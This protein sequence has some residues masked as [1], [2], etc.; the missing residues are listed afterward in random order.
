[1]KLLKDMQI[2][3]NH[4]FNCFEWSDLNFGFLLIKIFICFLIVAFLFFVLSFPYF[5]GGWKSKS[6]YF[7][8]LDFSYFSILYSFYIV[9]CSLLCFL[10]ILYDMCMYV[11]ICLCM[12]VRVYIFIWICVYIYTYTYIYIYFFL[13]IYI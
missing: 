7:Q 6:Y 11:Y 3:Q 13:Y 4:W 2:P 8:F 9:I 1:M 5:F 10:D 12:S